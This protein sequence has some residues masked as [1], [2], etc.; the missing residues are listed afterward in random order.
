[1]QRAFALVSLVVACSVTMGCGS[2][3]DSSGQGGACP[4]ATGGAPSTTGLV[5]PKPTGSHM[6]GAQHRTLVDSSREEEATTVTGDPR[7]IT[8]KIWYP[9][10]PCSSAPRAPYLSH[11]E[12]LYVGLGGVN[13]SLHPA[14]WEDEVYPNARDAPAVEPGKERFPVVVMSHGL[15][16]M[17]FEYTSYA[18]QLASNGFIVAGISHAYDTPVTE[19][20]EDDYVTWGP[21]IG[22]FPGP[23]ASQD[24]WDAFLAKLDVHVEVWAKDASFVLDELTKVDSDDPQNFFTGRLDLEHV[25][26]FGHSYGGATSARICVEDSRFDAGM[27]M[28][29]TFFG[30]G[31]L[32]GGEAIPRPFATFVAADH[33]TEDATI[34]GTF[35][36]VGSGYKL[37]LADSGHGTFTEDKLLFEHLFPDAAP[38]LGIF[39]ALEAKRSLEIVSAYT[40]AFFEQELKGKPSPLL[41]GPSASYPEITIKAKP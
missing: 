41:A 15:G 3:E 5:L 18:E 32:A 40:V 36:K 34:D 16:A 1:M 38:D 8:V 26:M 39:G 4:A 35:A 23:S 6:I 21:S 24:E 20:A 29:G 33:P 31:R 25:G 17:R 27:N 2:S 11:T 28:D 30:P 37:L 7:R 14:S 19:F 13:P 10:D 9:S 22:E 12:A